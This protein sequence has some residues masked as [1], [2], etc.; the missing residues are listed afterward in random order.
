MDS[1]RDRLVRIE[2]CS[3]GSWLVGYSARLDL[4]MDFRIPA[5]SLSVA[6]GVWGGVT[7]ASVSGGGH[8]ELGNR[9]CAGDVVSRV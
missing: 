5:F 9:R 3:G 2:L 4:S 1:V 8:S 7:S 6:D